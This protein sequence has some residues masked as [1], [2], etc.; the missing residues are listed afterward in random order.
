MIKE[1]KEEKDNKIPVLAFL[2]SSPLFLSLL[3]EGRTR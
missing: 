3:L 1:K 2:V